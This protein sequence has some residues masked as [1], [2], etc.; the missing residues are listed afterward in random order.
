[1]KR[2]ELAGILLLP[3]ILFGCGGQ[4]GGQDGSSG[5]RSSGGAADG[6]SEAALSGTVAIDGSSTVFP[7]T[8]AVAEEFQGKYPRVR[9]TVGL[10]GTGGGFKKFVLGET[11]INDASR[12]IKES[13]A[14]AAAEHGVEYIEMPVAF[15]GLTVIVNPENDWVDH[16]TVEE[17]KKIWQPGSTV[18]TWRDVRAE[19]PDQTINL[20]GPGVDSG[21]FDY[22]TEAINGESRLSR[23]DY[24]ASEDDNVLVSGV[25]GDKNALGYF[26]FAYY[27]ENKES[28]RAVPID[29]GA[30]PI[31]P[32]HD[33]VNNGT[34]APLSRPLFMYVRR[35]AADRPEVTAFVRFYMENAETLVNEIGYVALPKSAYALVSDRFE[36]RVTGSVYLGRDTAGKRVEDVLQ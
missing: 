34:Y 27:E 19:W 30:G 29:G 21:T 6:G 13:E 5:Q 3:A 16:L 9:V 2:Y 25:S 24:T 4:G 28:L 31:M 18:K 23:S 11:D 17:L 8:E 32:T 22:F 1:M 26:G 35:D 20:Y 15:D 7:I 10:S 33:S 12:V 14:Q 36:K